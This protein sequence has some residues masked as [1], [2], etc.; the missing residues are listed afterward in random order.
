MKL[1]RAP[2]AI[3]ARVRSSYRREERS[4][5]RQITWIARDDSTESGWRVSADAGP[6]C[7]TCGRSPGST[8][9]A[10]D[11][12]WFEPNT[13]PNTEDGGSPE[14]P[15]LADALEEARAEEREAC[16]R[17]ADLGYAPMVATAIRSRA[18]P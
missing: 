15:A 18:A 7:P 10:V 1:E 16:A 13:E 8:V 14:K 3:G 5:V 12:T 4:I 9:E 17:I 2:F 11:S 6:C